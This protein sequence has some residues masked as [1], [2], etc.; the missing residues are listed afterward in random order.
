M[1]LI[2]VEKDWKHAEGGHFE[3]QGEYASLA[4]G[5]WTPLLLSEACTVCLAT[6]ANLQQ[7]HIGNIEMD[8]I[9]IIY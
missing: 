9:E 7:Q 5:G 2:D 8:R 4:L 1:R 6:P 3:G